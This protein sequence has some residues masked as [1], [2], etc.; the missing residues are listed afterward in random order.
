MAIYLIRCSRLR[1]LTHPH[2]AP[3]SAIKYTMA[4]SL[5]S[6]APA[7]CGK[8]ASARLPW[9]GPSLLHSVLILNCAAGRSHA[10]S[11]SCLTTAVLRNSRCPMLTLCRVAQPASVQVRALGISSTRVV[12]I[13]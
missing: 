9:R 12:F 8:G 3:T 1:S 2:F 5:R 13:L 4:M 11:F 6:A 7:R 10:Y